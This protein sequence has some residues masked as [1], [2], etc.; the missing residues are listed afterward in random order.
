MARR[1]VVNR[2][3]RRPSARRQ[4]S[5]AAQDD[6]AH[7]RHLVEVV[8]PGAAEGAVRGREAG[9]LDDVGLDPEAGARRRIVPVFC[10]MSGS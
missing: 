8:H 10:G 3:S 5:N 1:A 6:V 7:E 2:I 9:R 4:A